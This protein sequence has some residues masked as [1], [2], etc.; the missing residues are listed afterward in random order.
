[1][2]CR[3]DESQ[4]GLVPAIIVGPAHGQ[5][6]ANSD[7]S[8]RHVT[9]PTVMAKTGSATSAPAALSIPTSPRSLSSAPFCTA[10]V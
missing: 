9:M 7:G 10:L 6:A 2:A 4:P 5:V 8:F 1:M 3:T